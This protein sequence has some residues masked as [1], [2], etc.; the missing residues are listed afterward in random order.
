MIYCIKPS[1]KSTQHNDDFHIWM[2]NTLENLL[3]EV[4]HIISSCEGADPAPL[5]LLPDTFL[6]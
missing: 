6:R 1:L 3:T 2:P 4:D 5:L